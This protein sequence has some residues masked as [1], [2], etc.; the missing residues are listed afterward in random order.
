MGKLPQVSGEDLIKFLKK[1]GFKAL[2]QKGSHVSLQKP[3]PDKP[4]RTV[5]PLH[6]TLAMGTL[7]NI[8]RQCGIS[9]KQFE[10]EF[11]NRK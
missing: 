1:Q 5:V 9:R 3:A 2:R 8:L 11:S 4:F 6:K 7:Y 10:K